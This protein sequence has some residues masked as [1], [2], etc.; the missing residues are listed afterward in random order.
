MPQ[1]LPDLHQRDA[2]RDHVAGHRVAEAMRATSATPAR[3]HARRTVEETVPAA[4]GPN[5][6]RARKNTSRRSLGGRPRRRYEATAWPTSVGRGN[7]SSRPPLPR[8][9]SS[10]ARQS[11]SSSLRPATS[12][13][14][15]PSRSKMRITAWSRRPSVER[16][17]Q[18]PSNARASAFVIP[19]GTDEWRRPV[20]ASAACDRSTSSNPSMKQKRRNDRSPATKNCVALTDSLAD[21]RSTAPLT[22]AAVNPASPPPGGSPTANRCACLTYPLTVPVARP[23]SAS[24]CRS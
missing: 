10:P 18:Q 4:I 6:A 1:H 17:S 9:T 22:C 15:I 16:R 14:R 19:W 12:L 11:M 2:G 21:S 23:R 5:G 24:R 8:T 20:M 3:L 7:R 13:A